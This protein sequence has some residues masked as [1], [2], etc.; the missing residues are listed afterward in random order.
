MPVTQHQI[1]EERKQRSRD[2]WLSRFPE[3]E[4]VIPRYICEV[5]PGSICRLWW[6]PNQNRFVV[7]GNHDERTK[8]VHKCGL[9]T[10]FELTALVVVVQ[11]APNPFPD[12]MEQIEEFEN[13]IAQA[14]WCG[15][16]NE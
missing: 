16:N 8:I 7:V 2:A 14:A 9:V 11:D 15:R 13:R 5:P 1:S 12:L 10:A 4:D 6:M 3:P